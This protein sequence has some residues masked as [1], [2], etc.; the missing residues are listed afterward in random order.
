MSEGYEKDLG[1]IRP[2]LRFQAQGSC[3]QIF[4]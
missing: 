4:S 3:E 1:V 2:P